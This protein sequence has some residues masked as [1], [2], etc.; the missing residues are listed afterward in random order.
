MMLKI[1]N[2]H[3]LKAIT[4]AVNSDLETVM[5]NPQDWTVGEVLA[6]QRLSIRLKKLTDTYELDQG[7]V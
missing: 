2:E 5:W 6:L 7:D 3:E 4:F 1:N